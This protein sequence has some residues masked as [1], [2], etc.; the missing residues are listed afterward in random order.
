MEVPSR[1]DTLDELSAYWSRPERVFVI[2][3]RGRLDEARQVIGPIPPLASRPVGSNF[4]Y[5]FASRP[6]YEE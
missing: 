1:I 4:A 5:L 2:V 3:E 6:G